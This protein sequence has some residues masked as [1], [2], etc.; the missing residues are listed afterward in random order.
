LIRSTRYEVGDQPGA[1]LLHHRDGLVIE[2]G[3]V[4]DRGDAGADR[5]LDALGAVRVGRDA[6]AVA[7]ASSTIA[8]SSS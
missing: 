5:G 4:L 7:R 8:F 1:A 2:H 6:D 3:A